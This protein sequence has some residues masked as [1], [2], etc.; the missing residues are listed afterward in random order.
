[1]ILTEDLRIGNWITVSNVVYRVS[2]ISETKVY[3]EG[4][5]NSVKK[6]ELQ[7]IPITQEILEKAGFER[8]GKTSLY[9]KIPLEGFTYHIYWNKIM[10][11]HAPD[12]TLCHW[13]NT[14]IAF[15]HQLQNFYYCLT[16]REI[17]V[18]F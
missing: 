5:K 12:N 13:L 10:V 3:F 2:V 15:V 6:E 7:P 1:M 9:D 14:R 11:F 16:G 17:S 4:H 8:R 18:S